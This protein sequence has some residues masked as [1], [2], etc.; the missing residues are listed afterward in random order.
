[1]AISA[2]ALAIAKGVGAVAGQVASSPF[3]ALLG[4]LF[5]EHTVLGKLGRAQLNNYTQEHLTG[6]QQEANQFSAD[7]AQKNREFQKEQADTTYQ[8]TVA[9]LQAAGLNPALA[10]NNGASVPTPT[11]GAA[12][13][14]SPAGSAVNLLDTIMAMK[15]L[16]MQEKL[17]DAE[18][19][20]KNANTQKVEAEIPWIDRLNQLDEEG[21]KLG[22]QLTDAQIANVKEH[23][24]EIRAQIDNLVQETKN[25][26]EE[27]VLLGIKE[28]IDREN[29][30]QLVEMYPL[31]L[32]VMSADTEEK[33]ANA[34]AAWAKAA[35][36]RN[37]ISSDY[38][39]TMARLNEYGMDESAARAENVR[40]ETNRTRFGLDTDKVDRAEKYGEG[41]SR[42][43]QYILT[44]IRR[45]EPVIKAVAMFAGL[46]GAG[47]STVNNYGA[48]QTTMS[49]NW[50]T[51][52]RGYVT[53]MKW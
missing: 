15:Q 40:A 27:G 20:N 23:T 17:A 36:D 2:T 21:K 38:Y 46:R 52:E 19:A 39:N 31:T 7:E 4:N 48:P 14:V 50:S 8:R 44:G 22:L 53:T 13:S 37:I 42:A 47:R 3:A 49:H 51:G 30:R 35:L 26:E 24:K 33:Q 32:A 18:V 43:R 10:M 11:G 41:E 6:A 28:A 29:Y 9:D 45:G 16:K 5:P 12:S 34:V 25:K 1:M